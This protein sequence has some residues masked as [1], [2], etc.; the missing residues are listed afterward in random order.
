MVVIIIQFQAIRYSYPVTALAFLTLVNMESFQ[1]VEFL[2]RLLYQLPLPQQ[3]LQFR[4]H[5]P[6]PL[7]YH[8]QHTDHH[9]QHP[10]TI[11]L[12]QQIHSSTQLLHPQ[13][14]LP[15][16]ISPQL[17]LHINRRTR[18]QHRLI[19]IHLVHRPQHIRHQH[20][21]RHILQHLHISPLLHQYQL[22]KLPLL[23]TTILCQQ[24]RL[25]FLKTTATMED[26]MHLQLITVVSIQQIM[27]MTIMIMK[28]PK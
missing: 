21:R 11:I 4:P 6:H 27:K 13:L 26:L 1:E 18:Q 16:R 28:I 20:P 9:R 22:I 12:R 10:D 17:P 25:Y 8:L 2:P 14:E 3:L 23:D 19:S 24:I 15:R 7:L 5:T